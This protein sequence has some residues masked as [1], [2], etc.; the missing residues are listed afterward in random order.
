M[1]LRRLGREAEIQLGTPEGVQNG[2][3][4]LDLQL[5]AEVLQSISQV[6]TIARLTQFSRLR[7]L[8]LLLAFTPLY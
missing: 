3:G 7:L 1:Q 2:A 8:A 4:V 6:W 5:Q